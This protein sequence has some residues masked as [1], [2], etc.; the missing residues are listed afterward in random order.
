MSSILFNVPSK[1]KQT[2]EAL[3]GDDFSYIE[4]FNVTMEKSLYK[5]G[6]N[7]KTGLLTKTIYGLLSLGV[8]ITF[9][10]RPDELKPG[11]ARGLK[12]GLA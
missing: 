4:V 5:A 3:V 9:S 7:N 10:P 2:K 8:G 6:V 1:E 12:L 11:P